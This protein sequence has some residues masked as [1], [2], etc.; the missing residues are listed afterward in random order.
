ML[1]DSDCVTW[2]NLVK[3]Q[4]TEHRAKLRTTSVVYWRESVLLDSLHFAPFYSW[5]SKVGEP[6]QNLF[7]DFPFGIPISVS[8]SYLCRGRTLKNLFIWC[9]KSLPKTARLIVCGRRMSDRHGETEGLDGTWQI[10]HGRMDLWH[11]L[12]GGG[13]I[14]RFA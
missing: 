10:G 14:K 12:I 1:L 11:L 2:F 5:P 8:Q 4:F 3:R 9:L 6:N 7:Y 13:R